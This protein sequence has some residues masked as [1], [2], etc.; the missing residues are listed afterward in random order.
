MKK[1]FVLLI[2]LSMLLSLVSCAQKRDFGDS[3][4]YEKGTA[5]VAGNIKTDNVSA[6]AADVEA[7]SYVYWNDFRDTGT[8]A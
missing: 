5:Y 4:K 3:A 2:S 7:D 1:L 8:A 6:V